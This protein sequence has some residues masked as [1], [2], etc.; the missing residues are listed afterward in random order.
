MSCLSI[1]IPCY[2]AEKTIDRCIK[3]THF[4]SFKSQLEI[5]I[6]NDGSTDS[7]KTIL[8][9]YEN[10]GNIHI[11]HNNNHGLAVTRM[12]LIAHVSSPSFIF[13]D[14]D[15]YFRDEAIMYMLEL[16]NKK[17]D[18]DLYFFKTIKMKNNKMNDFYICHNLNHNMIHNV[19]EN[20]FPF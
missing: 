20:F 16:L 7:T 18:C 4:N 2:N 5:I 1:L 12:R 11:F 9:K 10:F 17:K 14:S 13:V 8:S 19:S 3:S 6:I 15:D